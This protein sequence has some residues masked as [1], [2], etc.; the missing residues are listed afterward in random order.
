MIQ[1]KTLDIDYN[2]PA[3]VAYQ[4]AFK[5]G[6]EELTPTQKKLFEKQSKKIHVQSPELRKALYEHRKR[7]KTQQRHGLV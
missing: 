1:I 7:N 2:H 3:I 6:Y 4:E 5:K